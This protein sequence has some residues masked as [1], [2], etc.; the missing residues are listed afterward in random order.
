YSDPMAGRH[1]L[2]IEI[3]RALYMDEDS[4]RPSKNYAR[5]KADINSLVAAVCD[6]A[7]AQTL[8]RAAE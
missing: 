3:S 2:Q 5:L 1:S 4:F 7:G 6:Y 8:P